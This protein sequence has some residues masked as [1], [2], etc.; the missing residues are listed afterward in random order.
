MITAV[1]L[2]AGLPVAHADSDDYSGTTQAPARVGKNL[3][4]VEA[5]GKG[6]LYGLGYERVITPRLAIGAAGSYA[7]LSEQRV[8]TF[9]PYVHGTLLEGRRHAFFTEVGA[10]LAQSHLPSPVSGWDGMTTTGGGG[11]VSLGWE[12]TREHFF[13]RTSGSIVAGDGGIGPTLGFALGF[14]L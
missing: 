12:Y 5:L 4:Y 2:C 9:A 7:V 8:L 11:F 10:I 3:V 14:R 6:G 1:V 13:L